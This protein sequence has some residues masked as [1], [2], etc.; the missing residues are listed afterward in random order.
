M[1][2]KGPLLK[3]LKEHRPD[4]IAGFPPYAV[5]KKRR[6]KVMHRKF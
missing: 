3:V 2:S 6:S 1:Y 5:I 4:A